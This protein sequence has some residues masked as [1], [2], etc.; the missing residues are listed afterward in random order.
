[1][2]GASYPSLRD[3]VVLITG[4]GS[5]IGESMTRHFCAQGAR[6]AFIDIKRE[7]SERLVAEL[8]GGPHPAPRFELADLADIATLRAAVKRLTDALGPVRALINN[9]AHDDRHPVDSVTPEYWDDRIAV[10][11]KHQFFAA[12]A[13]YKGMA[14]A[15]GGS[16]VNLGSVSW[17][18]AQGGMPVY[19]TAKSAVQGLTRSLAR[20]FGTLDIRVNTLVPGWIMT[21]RQKTLWLTPEDKAATLARQCLKRMLDP[22]D[23]ARVALFLASDEA[24]GCTNQTFIVDAGLI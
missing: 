11:L 3:K 21:E 12:Q 8:S 22:E 23:V 24:A 19:T 6:V 18:A 1:M 10:N 14:A 4:G 15:G 2:S 20:D 5:G 7:E 13:V 17:M 16:I 9:A